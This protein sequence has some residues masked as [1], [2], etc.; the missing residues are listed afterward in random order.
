MLT[1][2]QSWR[3][4]ADTA[5]GASRQAREVSYFGPRLHVLRH[6]PNQYM[7]TSVDAAQRALNQSTN[8]ENW[9][10]NPTSRNE[11]IYRGL[12][13][14][15]LASRI[16]QA[17]SE[18][19]RRNQMAVDDEGLYSQHA[20]ASSLHHRAA[21]A[22]NKAARAAAS[23]LRM[24]LDLHRAFNQSIRDNPNDPAHRL[25]FA[26]WL[27]EHGLGGPARRLRLDSTGHISRANRAFRSLRR[28][29]RNAEPYISS[30]LGVMRSSYLANLRNDHYHHLEAIR[31]N[32]NMAMVARVDARAA[33][34]HG[35]NDLVRRLESLSQAYQDLANHHK[36]QAENLQ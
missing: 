32:D 17:A 14:H 27:D 19:H 1:I 26:D 12:L 9:Q 34:R 11:T 18:Y 28:Q 33:R 24:N 3:E 30:H 5:L 21:L 7:R 35:Y 29:Y 22:H 2:N 25:I 10:H 8:L 31:S 6:R 15:E 20:E 23:Q 4:L 16:H 36:Q 13:Y